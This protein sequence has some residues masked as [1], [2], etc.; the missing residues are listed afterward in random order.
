VI[1]V[2]HAGIAGVYIKN[3]FPVNGSQFPQGAFRFGESLVRKRSR[4]LF[5]LA[6]G[7]DSTIDD[8]KNLNRYLLALLSCMALPG[9]AFAWVY[10]EHRDIAILAEGTLDEQHRAV[11]DQLWQD[12]RSAYGTR[13]CPAG[14]EPT[15]GLI[16]ECIDWAALTAIAGDHAC[17]SQQMLETVTESDWILAVAD[18]AAQLK[19]DLSGIPIVAPPEQVALNAELLDEAKKR[20]SAEANRA[21]RVNALRVADTRMQRA[22]AE[23]ATRAASNNAHFLLARMSTDQTKEEYANETLEQGSELSAIGVYASFHLSALQKASRLANEQ[24]DGAKR[25]ALARSVLFDEAFALHFLEDAFASGHVAGTWGDAAQR[26]GTHDFYNQNGLETFTW[27]GSNASVVLMGDAHMRPRDAR[28]AANAVATSL[29]QVLDAATAG[30]DHPVP[31]RPAA[32]MT[33][34]AFDVCVN[35]VLPA[36]EPGL[37]HR[38]EYLTVFKETLQPTPVPRLGPGLGSM[39]RFHSELGPFIDLAGSV[40]GKVVNGGFESSQ[41]SSGFVGGMD[42]SLRAGLG[43]EGALGEASDG[44]V[45]VSLGFKGDA[46]STNRYSKTTKSPVNGNLGAAIPARTG[47]SFR[48]RMPYYVVPGDLLLMSPMY[49]FKPDMYTRMAVNAANGGLLKWQQGIAT[50]VGRFQF[51]LGR[52]LG[53]TFYG[54][55]GNDQLLAPDPVTGGFGRIVNFKS[56]A[57]EMPILE[58]RPFRSFSENQSSSIIFQLYGGAD[59]PRGEKTYLPFGALTPDLDTIWYLGI[60]MTFDWRYYLGR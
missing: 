3:G 41:T 21:K 47:L 8:M 6:W 26:K 60:R 33:P 13:L 16:P 39:P 54:L 20:L 11:F 51:V 53:I 42:I 32:P 45:F 18:I 15:Q 9:P 55:G 29:R 58:Y 37:E 10:P 5:I 4:Y 56:T 1:Y 25:Q 46:A 24:L 50:A 59:V 19:I 36:R 14:V 48:V 17:S 23:Y 38:G 43:L 34:D 30:S 35:N 52:E 31:Y 57:Y 49:F 44:L 40:D 28:I 12:A 7:H 2:N 27:D 22:D